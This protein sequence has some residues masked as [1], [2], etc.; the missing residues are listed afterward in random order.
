LRLSEKEIK[1]IKNVTT[2]F[3][4]EAKIYLFGSRLDDSKRGGDIDLFI[5]SK[6]MNYERKLKIRAKL[7]ALLKKPVDV[8]CHKDF[9]RVIEK[10][11]LKGRLL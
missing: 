1:I 5:V 8:V 10:E 4:N 9:N 6:D 3:L 7:K 11:A 2:Q